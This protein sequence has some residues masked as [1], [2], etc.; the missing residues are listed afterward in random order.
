[1]NI[2]INII[3]NI[4]YTEAMMI[5]YRNCITGC[6]NDFIH[7]KRL[8][9]TFSELQTLYFGYTVPR[10]IQS[11][12]AHY[13]IFH[14]Q[15]RQI[16]NLRNVTNLS[17]RSFVAFDRELTNY[18]QIGC[19][20]HNTELSE[21]HLTM[22]TKMQCHRSVLPLEQNEISWQHLIAVLPSS[23]SSTF[24]HFKNSVLQAVGIS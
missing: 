7:R 12:P 2:L 4:I 21:R 20:R 1:M 5:A 15:F 9:S 11:S 22:T 13:S 17:S 18:E 16:C 23:S 3:F 6:R 24:I 8:T 19:W 14:L 10:T